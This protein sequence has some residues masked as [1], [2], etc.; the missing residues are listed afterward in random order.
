MQ[1]IEAQEEREQERE[2]ELIRRI[3]RGESDL[4]AQLVDRYARMIQTLVARI[5]DR[6]E[7]AEEVAQD[8]FVKAFRQ[9]DSFGGRSS[10]QTWIYRIACNTALSYA[11]RTRHRKTLSG[12]DE[13]RLGLLPD[14][15]VERLEEWVAHERRL[16][17]LTRALA[18][19][20]AEERALVTLFYYE[21]RPVSECAAITGL[22]ENNIKVRLHRIRKKLYLLVM[23]ESDGRN[24]TNGRN[25]AQ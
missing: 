12:V 9:L 20:E 15:E 11:R 16:E 18:R 21:E 24:E 5:I 3:L 25:A 22:T 8:V 23:D 1:Q 13:R 14:E 19:L 7:E 10:F 17:A 2:Q 4:Y 6:P